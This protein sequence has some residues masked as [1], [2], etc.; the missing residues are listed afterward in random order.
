MIALLL[1]LFV[2]VGNFALGFA[3][4]I[5]FGHGPGWAFPRAESVRG[6]LRT[7]LGLGRNADRPAH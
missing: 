4:A 3:L 1:L 7:M 2:A 6:S 5:Y